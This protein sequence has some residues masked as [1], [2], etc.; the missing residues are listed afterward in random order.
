[1][2]LFTPQFRDQTGS[3]IP[4][5]AAT[6][7]QSEFDTMSAQI[8]AWALVQHNP[9]GTHNVSSSGVDFVYHGTIILWASPTL[10][11]PSFGT[12]GQVTSIPVGTQ[13]SWLVCD[14]SAVSRT[15]YVRLFGVI[16]T[17]FGAGDGSTTFNLPNIPG[18]IAGV[19]YIILSGA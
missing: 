18:P 1:M 15:F 9:D 10:P 5:I 19:R 8:S 7:T 13:S 14:G 3:L 12:P 4:Q 11:Q 2:S 17:Q 6:A 16:G